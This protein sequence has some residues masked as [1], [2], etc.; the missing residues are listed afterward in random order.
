MAATNSDT[1]MQTFSY[2]H[3]GTS[4]LLS[5]LVG[6]ILVFTSCQ[7]ESSG[8]PPHIEF[9]HESGYLDHDTVLAIGDRVTIGVNA[10]SE[11][12][13]ITFFQV[14]FNNGM[15][16]ILL[17][18]GLN[19]PSLTYTLPII[20]SSGSYERWT[21][22]VMDRDRNKD[23]VQVL[24]TKS[25]TSHYG[26]IITYSDIIL[27]AQENTTQGSF[28]SFSNG[29]IFSL[30][31]AFLN[32]T[33]IDLIYY[34][35]QY[36]ATLSSPN[37]TEAPSYF[38]GPSGIANWTVKNE[39]RYDTTS[40]S[41]GDFDESLNDSLLLAVYEPT[42]GKRKVKFVTPGMVI[43][44]KSQGGRIGLL[45]ITG[46]EPGAAGTLHFSVKIEE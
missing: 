15:K 35:G 46:T 8:Y 40:L 7:E 24:L 12:S 34:Y 1:D 28:F 29:D 13:S 4:I 32:Q 22:M 18:S 10:F 27:G 33:F 6:L 43:S 14:T 26:D 17:D 38:T 30:D 25:E 19:K 11:A 2:R 20:K 3:A 45:K 37:E 5:L 36:E 21:F 41:S 23:S 16:Q 9:I 42:A 44:F 31:S 39:T